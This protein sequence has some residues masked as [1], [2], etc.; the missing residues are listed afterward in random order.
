MSW[1]MRALIQIQ[2]SQHW[3]HNTKVH[4]TPAHTVF[5]GGWEE[6]ECTVMVIRGAYT[7]QN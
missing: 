3:L 2:R 1:E 4:T 6:G 7:N 5:R